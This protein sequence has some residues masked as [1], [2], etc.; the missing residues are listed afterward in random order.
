MSRR[1]LLLLA[2]L[3]IAC[4]GQKHSPLPPGATVLVLGDSISYGTGAGEG[5][6]YP[7][8][9]AAATGW[10]VINAGVPGDTT[11]DGLRRLPALLD[12]HAPQLLLV[13]LGGND[14]LRKLPPAQTT[15]NLK[16]ILA[17]AQDRRVSVVLMGAPSPNLFGAA[18]GMLGDHP[19]YQ[20]IAEAGGV[21]LVSGVLGEVLSRSELK[22]DP[23]HPNA[24]GYR[25]LEQRLR[26]VLKQY[27]FLR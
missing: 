23:I 16:S 13:E 22:A 7:S 27:G 19:L 26:S 2:L 8:L 4:G 10:Q 21:P 15:A 14:F 24:A 25:E 1:W 20:E 6:D 9:L 17:L 11:A 18:L 12:Q 3:L 5:E